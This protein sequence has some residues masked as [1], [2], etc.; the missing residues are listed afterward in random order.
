MKKVFLPDVNE[1]ANQFNISIKGFSNGN[2]FKEN[3][4]IEFIKIMKFDLDELLNKQI[5]EENYE[6]AQ[7]IQNILNERS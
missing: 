2:D 3:D 7:I 5:E 1:F 6:M 4:W